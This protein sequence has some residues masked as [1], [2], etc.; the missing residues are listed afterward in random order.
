M[1]DWHAKTTLMPP[2]LLPGT[3]EGIGI[4][5]KPDILEGTISPFK[6]IAKKALNQESGQSRE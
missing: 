1:K 6:L 2:S 4:T 5:P 3:H